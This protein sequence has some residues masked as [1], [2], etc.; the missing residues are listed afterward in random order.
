VK[1]TKSK[2]KLVSCEIDIITW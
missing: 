1:I 2:N